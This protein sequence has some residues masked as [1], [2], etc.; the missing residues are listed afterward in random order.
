[1]AD[2]AL[3]IP[4]NVPGPFYVDETCIDC[5]MCRHIAPS[6]FRLDEE[7]GM[8]VVYRQPETEQERALVEEAATSCPYDSIGKEV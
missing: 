4:S 3:R 6:V 2:P 1:M 7:R 8:S 5:D